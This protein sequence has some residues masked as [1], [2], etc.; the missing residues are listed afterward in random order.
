MRY[1]FVFFLI[2]PIF[3]VGC[4]EDSKGL[5]LG[6]GDRYDGIPVVD[7]QVHTTEG[8]E[9][10]EWF[11]IVLMS[12]PFH[13]DLLVC[14]S[15]SDK[16]TYRHLS[17]PERK[18]GVALSDRRT[19]NDVWI[20][21]PAGKGASKRYHLSMVMGDRHY[22]DSREMFITHP[23]KLEFVDSIKTIDGLVVETKHY[24]RYQYQI[25]G[26]DIRVAF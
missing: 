6:A 26:S 5:L 23:D 10:K 19:L 4:G 14:I 17:L 13:D 22:G 11:D 16:Y 12:P 7:L 9:E 1:F 2:V 21:I 15:V 20:L 8:G 25:Y 24:P 18:D 3:F